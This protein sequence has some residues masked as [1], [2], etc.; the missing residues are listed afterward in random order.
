MWR[1]DVT[2]A[3]VEVERLLERSGG[4]L[5]ASGQAQNLCEGGLRL[6]PVD[7]EVRRLEE[8]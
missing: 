7:Q 8:G 1:H 2:L 6:G 5:A 3:L 4:F